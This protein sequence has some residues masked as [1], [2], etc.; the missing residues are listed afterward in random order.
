MEQ[1]LIMEWLLLMIFVVKVDSPHVV[2][3]EILEPIAIQQKVVIQR[4]ILV[5]FLLNTI[6]NLF[7]ILNIVGMDHHLIL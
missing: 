2:L 3:Q 1:A 4:L 5:M 7:I 6:L